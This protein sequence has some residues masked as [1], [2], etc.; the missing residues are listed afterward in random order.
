[1]EHRVAGHQASMPPY[2][3]QRHL[4]QTFVI[5]ERHRMGGH[6]D[7]TLTGCR[8][9]SAYRTGLRWV[10]T[11]HWYPSTSNLRAKALRKHCRS[12]QPD[13]PERE[14]PYIRTQVAIYPDAGLPPRG[15]EPRTSRLGGDR[16]SHSAIA[17]TVFNPVMWHI[18]YWLLWPW[19]W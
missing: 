13:Q 8:H 19:V 18:F 11:L 15:I 7:P 9:V 1:M 5:G 10:L 2:D 3:S 17:S 12:P 14:P 6:N 16:S 4:P